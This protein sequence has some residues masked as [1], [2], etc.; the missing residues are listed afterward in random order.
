M[1]YGGEENVF[2]SYF[3]HVK[4]SINENLKM[5]LFTLQLYMNY[6]YLMKLWEK[7]KD[8]LSAQIVFRYAAFLCMR[9]FST[10]NAKI[11]YLLT[12]YDYKIKRDIQL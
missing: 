10:E 1:E 2:Y 4:H 11:L 7:V 9:N 3:I 5:F 12:A 8:R 6:E